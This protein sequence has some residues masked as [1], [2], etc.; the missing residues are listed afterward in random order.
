MSL[1]REFQKQINNKKPTKT[2]NLLELIN[3]T[4]PSNRIKR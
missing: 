4:I 1:A 2:V 3:S